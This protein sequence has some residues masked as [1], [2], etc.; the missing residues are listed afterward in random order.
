MLIYVFVWLLIGI[1]AFNDAIV[2]TFLMYV[3]FAKFGIQSLLFCLSVVGTTWAQEHM[4]AFYPMQCL[5]GL[6]AFETD[7]VHDFLRYPAA[8]MARI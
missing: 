6:Q 3:Q 7:I 5:I 4:I 1:W 8:Y 2:K